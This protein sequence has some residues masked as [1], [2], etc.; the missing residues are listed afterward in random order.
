MADFP[1]MPWKLKIL[2]TPDEMLAVETLQREVWQNNDLDVVPLHILI[3]TAQNGGLVIGAYP[4]TPGELREEESELPGFTRNP[5]TVELIGFVYGFPG[6]YFTP[7]GARPK[8]CSHEL[9]VRSDYRGHG[10]AFALKRAQWQMVRHQGLD[11]ITWTYDPLLSQ[12]AFLNISRL[13]AVSC[14]YKRN[15]YGEMRDG[16]NA[17]LPSD[18]FQVDWWINTQRVQHRLSRQARPPLNLSSVL[19]AGAPVINPAQAGDRGRHPAPSAEPFELHQ[20]TGDGTPET[21]LLVEI[22]ADFQS[23]RSDHPE[24]ALEWRWHTRR[25]F[26]DLFQQGYW[27]TDFIHIPGEQA[28]SFYVLSHGES[29]LISV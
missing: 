4:R 15:L 27:V 1:H 2:E 25:L 16:L 13:G 17:G 24:L 14:T 18:R 21:V 12:N 23:L 29:T 28:R 19:S 10:L 3:T 26:E 8:H 6:L 7:D 20:D 5:Q 9:A 22:P 11:L